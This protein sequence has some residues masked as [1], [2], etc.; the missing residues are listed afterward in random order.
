MSISNTSASLEEGYKNFP[1]RLDQLDG[2]RKK[3]FPLRIGPNL[4][5]NTQPVYWVTVIVLLIINNG[6]AIAMP[7]NSFDPR[8]MAMGGTGVAVGDPSTAPFF[9]PAMLTASGPSKKYSVEFPIVGANL[10]DPSNMH[11]KLENVSDMNAALTNSR[12]ALTSNSASLTNNISALTNN[13]LSLNINS[14]SS[15][16]SAA[17]T[18]STLKSSFSS[19]TSNMIAAGGNATS[20]ASEINSINQLLLAMNNQPVQAK[21]GA[22]TVVGIPGKEWGFALYADTWGAMGGTLVYKDAGTVSNLALASSSIGAALSSSGIATSSTI[23]ALAAASDS[24]NAAIANCAGNSLS[25]LCFSTL[26]NANSNIGTASSSLASTATILNTNI[27]KIANAANTIIETPALQSKVHIRGVLIEETGISISHHLDYE[28]Q[29]FSI[30]LTP[31]IMYLHLFDAMLNPDSGAITAGLTGHDYLAEYTAFNFDM[32]MVKS[33]SNGM[34][35]GVVVKNVV[36]QSYDFKNAP[37]TGATPVSDGASLTMNPQARIGASY[38][39]TWS[40][41]A[42]DLDVTRNNPAGLENYSQYVGIGG[43]WNAFDWAQ[44]RAGYH[45]D[46]LNPSQPMASAGFGISPRIPYFMPHFDLAVTVSPNIF[47][48][49]WGGATQVGAA[50]RAGVNF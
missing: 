11:T 40:T 33:Y 34:R 23:T 22:A 1:V 6:I 16:T 27:P 10:Y 9:N 37:T 18:I 21:F 17:T 47:A 12:M 39:T 50:F 14:L 45:H 20:M 41:V 5:L 4:N 2:W 36:P 38:E 35:L 42:F 15:A 26:N 28:N 24:L 29:S 49:G 3:F 31:K 8:S 44:L 13:I 48:S 32:G 46:L 25:T 43:E 30:G 7:F 19:V